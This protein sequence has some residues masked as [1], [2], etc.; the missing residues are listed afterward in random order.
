MM[1]TYYNGQRPGMAYGGNVR[2]PGMKMGGSLKM[3]E[4]EGKK[5]PFFAADGK[6]KMA[7]GGMIKKKK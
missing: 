5:V 7:Y 1:K 6:G 3:V 2:K 4:K